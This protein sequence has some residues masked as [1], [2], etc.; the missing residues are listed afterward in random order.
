MRSGYQ[1]LPYH[2]DG[3]A[4]VQQSLLAAYSR[5]EKLRCMIVWSVMNVPLLPQVH[6]VGETVAGE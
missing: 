5:S 3:A 6:G 1:T 4:F 2:A